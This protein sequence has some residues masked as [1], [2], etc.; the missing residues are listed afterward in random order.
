MSKPEVAAPMRKPV[1]ALMVAETTTFPKS[2]GA[3]FV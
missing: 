3:V 1:T 2:L